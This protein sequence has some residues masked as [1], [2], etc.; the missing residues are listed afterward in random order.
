MSVTVITSEMS[1]LPCGISY[2][3]APGTE[4]WTF[5]GQEIEGRWHST[6]Y[7][8]GVG[9]QPG[10]KVGSRQP[11]LARHEKDVETDSK[12]ETAIS[13]AWRSRVLAP[14]HI[15]THK[16]CERSLETHFFT[17]SQRMSTIKESRLC[18]VG[19]G[20]HSRLYIRKTNVASGCEEWIGKKM[21]LKGEER[22]RPPYWSIKGKGMVMLGFPIPF[23]TC[24]AGGL[25]TYNVVK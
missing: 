15:H 18:S 25:W 6:T 3:Q 2:S 10:E 20:P 22:F 5:W 19:S 16:E 21:K 13:F 23:F 8:I 12:Q 14:A 7:R 24:A 4:A 17:L 1:L 11:N 9:F